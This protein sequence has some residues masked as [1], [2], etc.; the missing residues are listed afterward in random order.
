[1]YDAYISLGSNCEAGLQFRRIGYDESSFFRWV[2]SPFESTYSLI[3]N[4][5]Q[6]LYIKDNLVPAWDKMVRDSKCKISFH[7]HLLSK[8]D[9]QTGKRYFLTNYDFEKKYQEEYQKIQ[10][11]VEKWNNLVNSDRKVL[12]ILKEEQRGSKTKAQKLLNLFEQKY[13]NHD[14]TIAYVQSKKNHESDWGFDKLKNIYF[15]RFAPTSQAD[16]GDIAAWDELFNKF[17]LI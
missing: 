3:K 9:E 14:F 11:F 2:F 10:Y 7:S 13:P 5:F 16:D 15:P 17:P 8:Q 6:D 4:D 1:M 12:Y